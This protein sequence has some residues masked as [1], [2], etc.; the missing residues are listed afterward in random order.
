MLS[1]SGDS[2]NPYGRSRIPKKRSI[3]MNFDVAFILKQV[4]HPLGCFYPLGHFLKN[5]F[6]CGSSA[7]GDTTGG[8]AVCVNL[9]SR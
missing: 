9:G 6:G 4:L 7:L 8:N 1:H 5:L 3:S 2:E